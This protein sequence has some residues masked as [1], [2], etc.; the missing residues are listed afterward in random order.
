[1]LKYIKRRHIDEEEDS[2]NESKLSELRTS[3]AEKEVTDKNFPLKRQLLGYG[4][5]LDW[6]RRLPASI[7]H[8]LWGKIYLIWL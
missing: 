4:F 3:K 8:C 1:M 6:R 2:V 5:Y 7:V